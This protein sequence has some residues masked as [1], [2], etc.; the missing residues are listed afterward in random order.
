LLSLVLKTA[1]VRMA[2]VG[3]V[4]VEDDKTKDSASA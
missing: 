1:W 2:V 4:V 3:S